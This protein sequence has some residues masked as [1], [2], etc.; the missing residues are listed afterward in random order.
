MR[1]RSAVDGAAESGSVTAEFAAVVPAVV[2]VL[3]VS[4]GGLQLATRQ[5][6]LQDAAALASRSVARG[7]DADSV[8]ESLAPGASANTEFRGNLVC[9][10]VSTT[11]TPL[12]TILGAVRLSASSC[13]LAGGR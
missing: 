1:C 5:L 2:L 11:G 6:Q 3:A 13:A 4:L 9:V 10:R 8:V 7:S 12:S